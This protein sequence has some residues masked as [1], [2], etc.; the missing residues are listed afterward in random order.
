[1]TA[2]REIA[3]CLYACPKLPAEQ[4]LDLLLTVS[5]ALA[6]V[7]GLLEAVA[8]HSDDPALIYEFL[9]MAR[10]LNPA[11]VQALILKLSRIP[12]PKDKD[13]PELALDMENLVELA[14]FAVGAQ[15]REFF[16]RTPPQAVPR[17]PRDPDAVSLTTG[18]AKA[19]GPN[20]T[21]LA[22]LHRPTALHTSEPM[23]TL[24]ELRTSLTIDDLANMHEALDLREYL[25]AKAAAAKPKGGRHG[26]H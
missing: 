20:L 9:D 6:P 8:L 5:A 26:R 3:G 7:P 12:S 14:V 15:F 13:A 2:E 11:A 4:G 21:R 24:I 25:V 19:L 16:A 10:A 18:E 17:L 23:C 22:Y 1:M